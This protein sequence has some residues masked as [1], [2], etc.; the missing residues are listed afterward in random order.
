MGTDQRLNLR[1]LKWHWQITPEWKHS[2]MYNDYHEELNHGWFDLI[3]CN[4]FKPE[5]FFD[6]AGAGSGV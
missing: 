5:S 4:L 3:E 1:I 6:G 2:W